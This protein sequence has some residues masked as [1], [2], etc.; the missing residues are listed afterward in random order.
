M[1]RNFIPVFSFIDTYCKMYDN[2]ENPQ[3]RKAAAS[4]TYKG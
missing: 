1:L 3:P 2:K 4:N